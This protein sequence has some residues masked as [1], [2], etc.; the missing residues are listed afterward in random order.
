MGK[1]V[2]AVTLGP[3]G[4]CWKPWPVGG[5]REGREKGCILCLEPCS[6]P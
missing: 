3:Q 4:E 5:G 6:S 2:A 1:E